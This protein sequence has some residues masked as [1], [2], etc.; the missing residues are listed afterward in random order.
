MGAGQV[1]SHLG[2]HPGV[3]QTV[4]PQEEGL[5]RWSL[6]RLGLKLEGV[7]PSW[8]HGNITVLD[9][10]DPTPWAW[11]AKEWFWWSVQLKQCVSRKTLYNKSWRVPLI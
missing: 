6:C 1:K 8:G 7:L 10:L 2:P 5:L 3:P 4:Q 11:E 9:P